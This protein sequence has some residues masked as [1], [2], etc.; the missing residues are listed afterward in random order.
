MLGCF[1]EGESLP[2][3]TDLDNSAKSG[4][5]TALSLVATKT[6]VFFTGT[7]SIPIEKCL[8]IT[9]VLWGKSSRSVI[10]FF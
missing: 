7:E 1:V 8:F 2:L 6:F 5:P 3:W 9:F 10:V 4:L